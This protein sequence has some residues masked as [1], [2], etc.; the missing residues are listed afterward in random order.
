MYMNHIE[1]LHQLGKL[2]NRKS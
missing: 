2:F 1:L